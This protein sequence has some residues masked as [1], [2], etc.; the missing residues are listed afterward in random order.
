MTLSD[1]GN[2][3]LMLVKK[4]SPLT[5]RALWTRAKLHM[6]KDEF[7]T[8][9]AELMTNKKIVFEGVIELDARR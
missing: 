4:L 8:A 9:L 6:S 1:N 7:I 3:L 2:E 5:S